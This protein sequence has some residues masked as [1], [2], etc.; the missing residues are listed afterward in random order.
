MT[1]PLTVAAPKDAMRKHHKKWN[2]VQSGHCT[3]ALLHLASHRQV[4]YHDTHFI[5]ISGSG[6]LHANPLS[7]GI[8]VDL[9]RRLRA[10]T[11]GSI[12]KTFQGRTFRYGHDP[13]QLTQ[14]SNRREGPNLRQL[15]GFL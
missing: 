5:D 10:P 4:L 13:D 12:P 7:P 11:R 3:V 8:I 6:N 1:F 15:T 9:S 2:V 14:V